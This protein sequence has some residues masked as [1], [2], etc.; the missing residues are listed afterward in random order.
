MVRMIGTTVGGYQVTAA[1][2]EGGMGSVFVARHSVIGNDAVVKLLKPELS[3][4]EEIVRRFFNEA[5]AAAAIGDPGIVQVFDS[6]YLPDGRAYLV[7]ERLRGETLAQRLRTRGVTLDQCVSFLRLLARTL[8]AAH[9]LGIIHRD[10]KPDNIYIVPDRDMPGG[11]RTKILDFGIAKLADTTTQ[12]ATR[13]GSIFGTPAYMAPEQCSDT[14]TVD[15]R[16]DLYAVGCI[17]YE[18]LSGA[19]PFGGGGLELLAAHLRDTP[20]PIAQRNPGVPPW[21]AAIVDRLL[22]KSPADRYLSAADLY[23]ALDP[24][25][26]GWVAPTAYSVPPGAS[27]P[28]PRVTPLP[29]ASYPQ[30]ASRPP[31]TTHTAAAGMV[32]TATAPPARSRAP[33]V[34]AMLGVA[35]A[36]ALTVVLVMRSQREG[37]EDVRPA[38]H[39]IDEATRAYTEGR[40]GDAIEVAAKIDIDDPNFNQAQAVIRD[41]KRDQAAE[42]VAARIKNAAQAGRIGEAKG[43]LATIP[44]ES[45]SYAKARA[46][47]EKAELAAQAAAPPVAVAQTEPKQPPKPDVTNPKPAKPTKPTKPEPTAP[48]VGS[49]APPQPPEEPVVDFHTAMTAARDAQAA[50]QWGSA[51]RHAKAALRSQPGNA[52]ARMIATKGACATGRA[53]LARALLPEKSSGSYHDIAKT[54]CENRGHTLD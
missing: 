20:V 40:W 38:K 11:E 10:L 34:I 29:H 53:H 39:L 16:A 9:A 36:A 42:L 7:M 54:F 14:A 22:Q 43:L 21:L 49:A 13:S 12:H 25:A 35:A 52:E 27:A 30:P 17:A 4:N 44:R 28:Q 18:M 19:P 51:F 46:H 26:V 24:N 2:A 45:P 47:I 32:Q 5:K 33:L 1:L 48:A 3:H 41:S 50:K 8:D 31:I 15:A 23:A 37:G 6:G